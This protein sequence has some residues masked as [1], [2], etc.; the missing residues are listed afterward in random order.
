[1][2]SKQELKKIFE[3]GDKPKQEDFW[4]WQDSYWHKE[5]DIIPANR[6]DLSGKADLVNGKVPSEQLPSYVD[7]I[8]EYETLELFPTQGE[9][10]KLFL[11]KS[12]NKLYRW[13]GSQYV[14]I[15]SSEVDTLDSVTL[16]GNISSVPI[17]IKDPLNATLNYY[18]GYERENGTA[19]PSANIYFGGMSGNATGGGNTSLS[20]GGL[21]GLTTGYYNTAIGGD[22]LNGLTTGIGNV[23]LG[24]SMTMGI[25]ITGKGNVAIGISALNMLTEGNRNIGIGTGAAAYITSGTDN[26]VIGYSAALGLK[27]GK[28]NIFIGNGS[29]GQTTSSTPDVNNKLCIESRPYTTS[30]NFWD[31]RVSP[32]LTDYKKGLISGDFLVREVNIDGIFS[33]TPSRIPNATGDNMYTKNIV[34][35]PD[36]TYG[37]EDK[38]TL[39]INVSKNSVF[40]S[41][42]IAG[43]LFFNTTDNK[44]YGFDGTNWNALY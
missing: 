42:P 24:G 29:G 27:T 43:D 19:K 36:G 16:R 40:P 20:A 21:K 44:H 23:A 9:M 5:E 38:K 37:W 35:K 13:S 41:T 28:N 12:S 1:M 10:G 25:D 33:Q 31:S 18:I 15:T 4:E 7:D 32:Y 2:K 30:S 17:N 3:N 11:A 14:D 22:S 34:A 8:L 6:V 26:I 39:E